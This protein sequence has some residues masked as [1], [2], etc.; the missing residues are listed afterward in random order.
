MNKINFFRKR[1]I[2]F[3]KNESHSKENRT[4]NLFSNEFKQNLPFIMKY[5]FQK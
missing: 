4:D 2:I 3:L 1:D 5:Q